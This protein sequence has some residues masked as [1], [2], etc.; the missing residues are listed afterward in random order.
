MT[1][2]IFSWADKDVVRFIGGEP[3]DRQD[4]WLTLARNA[5]LWTLLGFG[6]WIVRDRKTGDFVGD[7]GFA[8]AEGPDVYEL[9]YTIESQQWELT[10]VCLVG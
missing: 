1:R 7:M 8:V 9:S 6:P 10:R 4:S 2:S 5:G 3:R